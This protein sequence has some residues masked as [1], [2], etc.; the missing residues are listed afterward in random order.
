MKMGKERNVKK[1][2]DRLKKRCGGH[3]MVCHGRF[4]FSIRHGYRVNGIV[5]CVTN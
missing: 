1:N 2:Y 5:I 3:A 4:L